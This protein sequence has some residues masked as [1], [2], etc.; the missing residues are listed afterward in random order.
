MEIEFTI[1]ENL[2]MRF[3]EDTR[4]GAEMEHKGINA[5]LSQF[6]T[7]SMLWRDSIDVVLTNGQHTSL[8]SELYQQYLDDKVSGKQV[9]FDANQDEDQ[10]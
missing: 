8:D 10:D 6:Y 3:I 1:D 5:L 2:L 9:T 4:P 7:M